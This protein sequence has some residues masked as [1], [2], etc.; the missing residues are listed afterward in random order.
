MSK[1]RFSELDNLGHQNDLAE[2]DEVSYKSDTDL[3]QQIED[4][5]H[6]ILVLQKQNEGLK[7]GQSSDK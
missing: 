4:L 7:S 6:E 3:L 2:M 1:N 5:K